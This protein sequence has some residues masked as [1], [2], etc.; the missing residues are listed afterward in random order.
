MFFLKTVEKNLDINFAILTLN[1]AI[2]ALVEK[3]IRRFVVVVQSLS[4]VQLFATP[5]TAAH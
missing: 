4:R 2:L 1:S 3:V 5:W